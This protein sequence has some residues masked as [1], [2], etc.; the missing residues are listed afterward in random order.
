ML[1]QMLQHVRARAVSAIRRRLSSKCGFNVMLTT[2]M[3][4]SE[5]PFTPQK[6]TKPYI[7]ADVRAH[8]RARGSGGAHGV[9]TILHLH[10]S[11]DPSDTI[12]KKM[13]EKM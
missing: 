1:A 4:S 13:T 7:C 10:A 5:Q 6:A 3:L 9:R 8:V 12:K 2:F 11:K